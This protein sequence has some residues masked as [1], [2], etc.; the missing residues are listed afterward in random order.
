MMFFNDNIFYN[1]QKEHE[2]LL[3]EK[4]QWNLHLAQTIQETESYGRKNKYP[5]IYVSVSLMQKKQGAEVYFRKK[6]RRKQVCCK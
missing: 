6:N 2:A 4:A 5:R 1:I 3:F